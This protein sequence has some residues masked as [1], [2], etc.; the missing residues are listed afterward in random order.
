M[1]MLETTAAAAAVYPSFAHN[2]G[3]FRRELIYRDFSSNWFIKLDKLTYANTHAHTLVAATNRA[4]ELI[5][6]PLK[7]HCV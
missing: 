3:R 5:Y 7:V 2:G 6:S 1:W 4:L